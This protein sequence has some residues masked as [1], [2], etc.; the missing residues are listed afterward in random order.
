[1][2]GYRVGALRTGDMNTARAIIWSAV[3]LA[4]AAILCVYICG[5]QTRHVIVGSERYAYKMNRTTGE[6]DFLAGE[7]ERSVKNADLERQK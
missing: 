2:G 7:E 5:H 1:M 3:I 6:V 4:I